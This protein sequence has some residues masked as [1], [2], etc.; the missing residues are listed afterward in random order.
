MLPSASSRKRSLNHQNLL[1]KFSIFSVRFSAVI[2]L[3]RIIEPSFSKALEITA[4][5][6]PPDE[7]L[8]PAEPVGV[9]EQLPQSCFTFMHFFGKREQH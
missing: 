9:Q 2:A 5:K 6:G 3:Q 8:S 7:S 1:R 4:G